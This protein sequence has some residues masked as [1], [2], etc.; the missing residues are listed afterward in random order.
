M[1][2]NGSGHKLS[3]DERKRLLAEV[4]GGM[5]IGDAARKYGVSFQAVRGLVMTDYFHRLGKGPDEA[6]RELVNGGAQPSPPRADPEL[7]QAVRT[8]AAAL[9]RLS[10]LV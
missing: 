4:A 7:R 1:A 3:D 8:A 6:Y 9:T 5:S 2:I 10:D